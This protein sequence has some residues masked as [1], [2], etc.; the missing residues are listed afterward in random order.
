LLDGKVIKGAR[1]FERPDLDM[2]KLYG[3]NIDAPG[4]VSTNKMTEAVR[5]K[6]NIGSNK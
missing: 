1:I 5:V 6:I 2:I 4:Y 3:P